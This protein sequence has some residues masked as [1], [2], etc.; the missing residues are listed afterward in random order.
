M[1]YDAF[2][3]VNTELRCQI[4]VVPRAATDAICEILHTVV[5]LSIMKKSAVEGMSYGTKL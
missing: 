4:G 1:K 3:N 5:Q 2:L